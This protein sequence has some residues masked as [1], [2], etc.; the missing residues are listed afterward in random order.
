MYMDFLTDRC[1][2]YHLRSQDDRVGYGIPDQRLRGYPEKP[3]IEDAPCHFNRERLIAGAM[4]SSPR[5]LDTA[6]TKL[7]LPLGIDV[8]VN[9][10]IV[11][12]ESGCAFT[13]GVPRTVG[14][15]HH[16]AVEVW[17]TGTQEAM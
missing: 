10:R 17:R 4:D 16:I 15:G 11:D 9:D 3:D 5:R 7:Q 14:R 6:M 8:R 1:D 2:I 13:A 12:K